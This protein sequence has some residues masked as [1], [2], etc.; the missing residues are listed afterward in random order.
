MPMTPIA[1]AWSLWA[2]YGSAPTGG[3]MLSVMHQTPP[4]MIIPPNRRYNVGY[5]A[6]DTT[7][8]HAAK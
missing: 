3:P 6:N 7:S 8:G 2:G 5:E 4:V 1:I